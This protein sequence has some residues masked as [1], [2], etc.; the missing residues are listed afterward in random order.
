MRQNLAITAL[1]AAAALTSSAMADR[2]VLLT[3]VD[4][5]HY[6]GPERLLAPNPGPG[7]PG[8]VY[9]GDR[10]AGT[11]DIGPVVSY[12]GT[13]TPRY[14]PNEFGS[15]SM[16]YRRGLIPWVNAPILGVEFLGGELLDLDGDLDNGMRSL[17]PIP[18]V[19]PVEIPGSDSF[20]ELEFDTEAGTTT[21][22]DFDATGNNEGGP[23]I[24]PD[25]ATILVT[26]AGTLPN[27]DKGEPL[28]PDIDDRSGTLTPFSGNSGTLTSVY[29]IGG[30]GFELWEDAIDPFTAT[31]DDL[32]TMQFLGELN[33]WLVRRDATTGNFPV[34]SGEGLGSTTWP[35]VDVSQVGNSFNTATGAG[36]TATIAVGIGSDD[37]STPGNGGLALTDFG[38]DLGAYLDTVVAPLVPD[39]DAFVYLESVGFGI[40]NS[41]DPVYVDTIG[42]DVVIIAASPALCGGQVTGD[43][44]CDGTV[45]FGDINP[46]VAA[47]SGQASW[48]D[49]AGPG[50]DYLCVNDINRDGVVDF[51]DINPFVA[52]L[53]Q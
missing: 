40:N 22:V 25:I 6:P 20:I 8:P 24:G 52:V 1:L 29:E 44:N 35:A 26:I 36:A 39:A 27:G 15:L 51:D 10:L 31:P 23:G 43:A 3:G 18:G 45:D 12:V 30:V 41:N 33:G 21:L 34:L 53:S 32:G 14:E 46:F 13:G 49:V 19:S 48:E 42:Y 7:S 9:D 2:F 16:L 37:F 47:L 17:I 38:G 50:C 5:R 11:S 28:N 4:A